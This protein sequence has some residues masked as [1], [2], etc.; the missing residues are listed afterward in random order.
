M[1]DVRQPIPKKPNTTGSVKDFQSVLK[2]SLLFAKI[3]F[4]FLKQVSM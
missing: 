3:I 2:V 1:N 4:Y